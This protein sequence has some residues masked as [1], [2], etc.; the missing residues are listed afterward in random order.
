MACK[1]LL[2]ASL[3]FK[4]HCT[5]LLATFSTNQVEIA[6][7]QNKYVVYMRLDLEIVTSKVID[8]MEKF[9]NENPQLEF[10]ISRLALTGNSLGG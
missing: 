3:D 10:D 4:Q 2:L 5:T 6:L 1:P 8:I 9:C 7:D